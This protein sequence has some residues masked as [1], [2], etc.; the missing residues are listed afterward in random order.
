MKKFIK[1]LLVLVLFLGTAATLSSCSEKSEVE[2]LINDWLEHN[3]QDFKKKAEET[4]Y[5]YTYE[6]H[7]VVKGNDK[8]KAFES[9]E[10]YPSKYYTVKILGYTLDL[11]KGMYDKTNEKN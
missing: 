10:K 4:G 6:V 5:T 2:S 3:G 9:L 11:Y 7:Y 8:D 1:L